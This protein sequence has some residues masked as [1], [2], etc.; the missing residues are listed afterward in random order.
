M[1]LAAST[2]VLM[3][4]L[5]CI[6]TVKSHSAR[7]RFFFFYA[8]RGARC[9]RERVSLNFHIPVDALKF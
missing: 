9:G 1:R 8:Q 5:K 7:L 2:Q 4:T 3:H 6:L